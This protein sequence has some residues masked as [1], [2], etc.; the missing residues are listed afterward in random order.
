MYFLA[1]C[2]SPLDKCLLKSSAH[3]FNE[4]NKNYKQTDKTVLNMQNGMVA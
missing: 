3:F 2:I 4:K 1:I